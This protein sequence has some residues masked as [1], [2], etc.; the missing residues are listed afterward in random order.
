MGI[1]PQRILN[2]Y[3]KDSSA[4][5]VNGTYEDGD[6]LIRFVGCDDPPTDACEQE[7]MPYYNI[8]TRKAKISRNQ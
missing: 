6:F 2:A 4:A 1:V 3:S 7:M 5:G 8:W